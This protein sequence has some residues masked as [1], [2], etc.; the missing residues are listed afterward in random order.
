MFVAMD[1]L[2]EL[3]VVK[4]VDRVLTRLAA[5]LNI[6]DVIGE[7][8]VSVQKKTRLLV[9]GV[10]NTTCRLINSLSEHTKSLK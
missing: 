10:P 2:L 5:E 4:P 7:L 9:E 3:S 1:V 8:L 6:G